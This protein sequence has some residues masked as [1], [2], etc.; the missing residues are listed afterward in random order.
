MKR[1]QFFLVALVLVLLSMFYIYTFVRSA[2]LSS[3]VLFER[4]SALDMQNIVD[5]IKSRNERYSALMPVWWNSSWQYR[6][7]VTITTTV[8]SPPETRTIEFDPLVPASRLL[9]GDCSKELRL[10]NASFPL[11]ELDSNVSATTTPG[12]NITRTEVLNCGGAD[13]TMV[14]NYYV[15]YGYAS[16]QTPSYRNTVQGT[17]T[18]VPLGPEETREALCNHFEDI[19]PKAGVQIDCK[20]ANF[21]GNKTNVSLYFGSPYLKFNGSIL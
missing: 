1:A 9:T 3:V 8:P 2:D 18:A 21:A 7:A 19:Y 5:S 10:T 13:C 14:L 4:T 20:I 16:A 6:K 17:E 15:Y 12:C 11:N